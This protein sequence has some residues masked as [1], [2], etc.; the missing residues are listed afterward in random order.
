MFKS[1]RKEQNQQD[2]FPITHTSGKEVNENNLFFSSLL[3]ENPEYGIKLGLP[4]KYFR[5]QF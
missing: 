2:S 5:V 1:L 4:Q 3:G